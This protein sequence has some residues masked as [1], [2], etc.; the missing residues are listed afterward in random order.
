MSAALRDMLWSGGPPLSV[1]LVIATLTLLAAG[2]FLDGGAPPPP[3]GAETT[4]AQYTLRWLFVINIIGTMV[5]SY[6]RLGDIFIC[7][8][9]GDR[10]LPFTGTTQLSTFT[11]WCWMLQ[12]VY[13]IVANCGWRADTLFGVAFS[14]ALLVSAVTYTVLGARAR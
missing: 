8:D 2:L 4:R 3:K 14:S 11:R 13:F 6:M 10:C 1:L 5:T 7:D 12:G 9:T